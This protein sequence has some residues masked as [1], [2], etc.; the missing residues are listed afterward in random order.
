MF[1]VKIAGGGIQVG[2]E[3]VQLARNGIFR[4]RTAGDS[5]LGGKLPTSGTRERKGF[6]VRN[7]QGEMDFRSGDERIQRL[8]P[9]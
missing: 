1:W 9:E 2:S 6:G 7:Y 3:E 5:G 4:V 8:K